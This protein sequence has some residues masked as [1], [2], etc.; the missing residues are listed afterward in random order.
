MI[1][2]VMLLG[3][4]LVGCARSPSPFEQRVVPRDGGPAGLCGLVGSSPDGMPCRCTADCVEGALCVS[5]AVSGYP[6]GVCIRSCELGVPS[7][8]GAGTTCLDL[9]GKGRGGAC[10]IPCTSSAD[11]PRGGI[12]G[13]GVCTGFCSAD[14]DCESGYCDPWR[15]RCRA[16]DDVPSGAGTWGPCSRSEECRSRACHPE[17]GRCLSPCSLS[18]NHC[19]PGEVCVFESDESMDDLG[20]CFP[21]CVRDAD[22]GEGLECTLGARPGFT[23]RVCTVRP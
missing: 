16:A 21:R 22:C 15:A 19:P 17:F 9:E 7:A 20:V 6:G 11:C 5:E 23:E 10:E 1:E 3:M 2:R 14:S 12:C 8:C 4:L 13:E 18:T